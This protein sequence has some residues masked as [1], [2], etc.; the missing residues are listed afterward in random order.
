MRRDFPHSPL[1]DP[2]IDPHENND[3]SVTRAGGLERIN[4]STI[5]WDGK[6]VRDTIPDDSGIQPHPGTHATIRYDHWP[7]AGN[8]TADHR[9]P[10]LPCMRLASSILEIL[11]LSSTGSMGNPMHGQLG[12]P[13][14][15]VTSR[16]QRYFR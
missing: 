4:V 2:W 7:W 11:P 9:G 3:S 1:V 12:R 6:P 15:R 14:T 8:L 10:K 5:W 13:S 16:N